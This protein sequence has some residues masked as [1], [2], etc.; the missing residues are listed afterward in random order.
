[1]LKLSSIG[2]IDN[3]GFRLF[4]T[5][6]LRQYDGGILEVGHIVNPFAHL[7]PPNAADYRTYG[8]CPADC[9]KAVSEVLK[10]SPN[11][12]DQLSKNLFVSK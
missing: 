5:D 2:I 6:Q 1:M 8:E 12:T 3:S 9:L 4:Y 11:K 10:F 7:I